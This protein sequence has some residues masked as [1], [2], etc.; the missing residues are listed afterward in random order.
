LYYFYS[1]RGLPSATIYYYQNS[2]QRLWD[3]NTFVQ[4]VLTHRFNDRFTYRNHTKI[5]TNFTHYLDTKVLNVQGFQSDIYQ[6]HEA[7]LNNVIAYSG[8][9][10]KL[11]LTNDLAYNTLDATSNISVL[12]K[13]F[14]SLTA[15]IVD[16]N[17]RKFTFNA[18]LL[19]SYYF[20]NVTCA[21]VEQ[22]K[23][24]FHPFASLS[25]GVKNFA[26]SVF[27]KD[28]FRNPT[29]NELYYNR[30][31]TPNL[32]PERTRQYNLHT[33]YLKNFESRQFFQINASLDVYYNQVFDKIVAMPQRNLF[34]WSMVNYGKVVVQGLDALLGV[35]TNIHGVN[36]HIQGTYSYQYA[37]DNE[38]NNST[39]KQQIPYTPR[40]SGSLFALL[41]YKSYS[42]SYTLLFVGRRYA[43]NENIAANRLNPY[44]EHSISL[45][46][47]FKQKL[48]LS[49]SVIN[50]FDTQYEVVRNYPMPMRQFRIKI[51]YKFNSK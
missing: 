21:N 33:A 4:S 34:V 25:Y 22:Y 5:S 11:S 47:T 17:F 30:V 37:I 51:N 9:Q 45:Q 24:S 13:R 28:I 16:Y 44:S 46:K 19:H 6:Q 41:N 39:Y 8:K 27:Y 43:L 15:M 42:L 32:K 40:S 14:T 1:N 48:S 2:G 36:I 7:Y 10:I 3:K 18:N 35:R 29:F 50:L 12:P 23:S 49:L 31:G 26:I 20:D 38:E